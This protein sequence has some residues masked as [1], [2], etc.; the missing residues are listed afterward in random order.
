MSFGL[1]SI[2]ERDTRGMWSW[3]SSYNNMKAD[4]PFANFTHQ[5]SVHWHVSDT[6]Q[7]QSTVPTKSTKPPWTPPLSSTN[8]SSQR[9]ILSILLPYRFLPSGRIKHHWIDLSNPLICRITPLTLAVTC[10]SMAHYTAI[11]V[12][13][14]AFPPSIQHHLVSLPPSPPPPPPFCNSKLLN[15]QMPI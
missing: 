11:K 10:C 5:W 15:W 8:Y 9:R 14:L 7:G 12:S 1:L 13:F 2:W 3:C 6:V 4:W